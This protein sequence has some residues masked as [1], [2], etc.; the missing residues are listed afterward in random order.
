MKL[1]N[2]PLITK[3]EYNKVRLEFMEWAESKD[4]SVGT[5]EMGYHW[6]DEEG[7]AAWEAWKHLVFGDREYKSS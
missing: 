4:M 2:K 5:D 1:S 7:A 3:Q 6:D